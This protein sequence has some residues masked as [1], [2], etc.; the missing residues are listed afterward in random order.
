[1]KLDSRELFQKAREMLFLAAH[2]EGTA[3]RLGVHSHGDIIFK[4]VAEFE[5]ELVEAIE[6]LV[7]AGKLRT[8]LAS[9]RTLLELTTSL[10]WLADGMDSRLDLFTSGRC[11]SA[12]RMMSSANL[13]WA[14]EYKRVYAPL[15]DFVHGSFTLIDFNKAEQFLDD[16]RS[17]PYSVLGDYFIVFTEDGWRVQLVEDRPAE[18]LIQAYGELI[19]AKAFDLALTMLI[20]ASGE[21]ADSFSWW[22]GRRE[23]EAFDDLVRSHQK[24]MNFL[25]LS[26]KK[27]LAIFR[28]EGRYA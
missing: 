5:C 12:Q 24:G 1:M 7:C 19:A 23:I 15:S 16:P 10:S 6:Q 9:L 11:P 18:E 13:G 27:R 26:E 22:P 28:V 8:A 21:Y 25:W 2:R 20:R 4:R 14:D 17:A 3:E